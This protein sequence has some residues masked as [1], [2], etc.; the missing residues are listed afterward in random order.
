MFWPSLFV[1]ACW[2]LVLLLLWIIYRSGLND[3]VKAALKPIYFLFLTMALWGIISVSSYT[4]ARVDP[5][6]SDYPDIWALL[7]MPL[8]L[9]G[10]FFIA[11]LRGLLHRTI[12]LRE[13]SIPRTINHTVP[14]LTIS[15]LSDLHLTEV[16]SL[17]GG[18]PPENILE[19]A[20]TCYCMGT[21]KCGPGSPHR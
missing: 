3:G 8:A 13:I 11:D 12:H 2:A 4:L 14:A 6:L 17:G 1:I 16:P 18:V 7:L 21:E 5:E 10:F 9:V 20:R 15:H 19:R